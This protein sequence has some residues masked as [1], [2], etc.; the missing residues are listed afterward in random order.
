LQTVKKTTW[1]LFLL[2]FAVSCLDEPE[3]Y[4]LNNNFIGV[5]FRVLGSNNVDSAIVRNLYIN[6]LE[7]FNKDRDSLVT[8]FQ[9]PLDYFKTETAYSFGNTMASRELL[10]SYKVQAQFVSEDCGPRYI[11][12][13]LAIANKETF[14][15]IR[16]VNPEPNR[17][18][19]GRNIEIFRCP[20]TDTLAI[21][22]YELTLPA[23]PTTTN[24]SR[25]AGVAFNGITV[26]GNVTTNEGV[27]KTTVRLPVNLSGDQTSYSFDIASGYAYDVPVRQLDV[28]YTRTQQTRWNQCGEQ[29]FVSELAIHSATFDSVSIVRDTNG[30]PRNTLTDPVRT[31]INIYRCPPTN[32]LQVAFARRVSGVLQG[33]SVELQ[34]VT[35]DYTQQ[36]FFPDTTVRIIQLPLNLDA[37][38]TTFTFAYADRQETITLNYTTGSPPETI[39]RQSCSG[40]RVV[41]NITVAGSPANVTR[42]SATIVYPAQT[43]ITI[44][45]PN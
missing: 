11:L 15:S 40:I 14:D 22:F 16:I 41:Q 21:T 43:N 27:R 25:L 45:I 6:G 34:G 9:L 7:V 17:E 23:T 4:L 24:R 37:T 20:N 18:S 44:E 29:T 3:C 33:A 10:M 5:Y 39:F 35:A 19:N 42:N 26:D 1:F 13:N 28:Q 31:N 12:S 2:L 30:F 36:V 8:N 32:L 38:S